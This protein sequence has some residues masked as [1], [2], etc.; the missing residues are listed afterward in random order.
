[1]KN[2][3]EE[4]SKRQNETV[5]LP[6]VVLSTI[7]QMLFPR[8]LRIKEQSPK[9]IMYEVV[10]TACKNLVFSPLNFTQRMKQQFLQ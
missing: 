8:F 7:T 10:A 3:Y 4:P 1:M 2:D 5:R 6:N 9:C